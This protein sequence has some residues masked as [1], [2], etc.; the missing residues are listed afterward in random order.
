MLGFGI[1]VKHYIKLKIKFKQTKQRG[2][3]IILKREGS[4][5][6]RLGFNHKKNIIMKLLEIHSNP[7]TKK[8]GQGISITDSSLPFLREISKLM[9]LVGAVMF[10]LLPFYFPRFF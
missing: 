8:L 3:R 4:K 6:K 2:K 7:I 9:K 10:D 1:F 5:L